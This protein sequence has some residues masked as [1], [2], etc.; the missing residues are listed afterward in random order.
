MAGSPSGT[1]GNSGYNGAATNADLSHPTEVLTDT[2]NN[3]YIADSNNNHVE[4]VA[5]AGGTQWGIAMTA[6]D[7]Y[8]I[9]GKS[10]ASTG[11]A[12]DGGLATSAYLDYPHGLA[13]D[14]SGN[15]YISDLDNNRIQELPAVSGSQWSQSMTADDVYTVAGQSDGTSG[16]H[17]DGKPA[18]ISN[19]DDPETVSLDGGGNLYIADTAN[20]VVRE[21]AATSDPQLAATPDDLY[22]IAGNGSPGDS[23]NNNGQATG[24]SISPG[25]GTT[26]VDSA[27]NIYFADQDNNRIEEVAA[28]THTQWGISMTA[29]DIHTV[30]G[31]RSGASGISG[32]VDLPPPRISRIRAVLPLIRTATCSFQMEAAESKKLPARPEPNGESR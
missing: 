13:I 6:D 10:N 22:T 9:V 25:S 27:G 5:A 16:Y 4:E 18:S 12:G 19:L 3:L 30:A 26:R 11:T 31:Q 17:G 28:T 29:G 24:A 8:V 2:Q 20:N 32:D 21:V 7:V 14:S 1:S 15:L 23:E